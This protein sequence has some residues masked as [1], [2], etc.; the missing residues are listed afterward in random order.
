MIEWSRYS[1]YFISEN[2]RHFKMA[3]KGVNFFEQHFLFSNRLVQLILGVRP[4][5]NFKKQLFILCSVIIY[6]LPVIIHQVDLLLQSTIRV[7]QKTMA[8]LCF[9]CAYSSTYFSFVTLRLIYARIKLDYEKFTDDDE[10]NIMKK[11]KV[12]Q[13]F[14]KHS[15]YTR[16]T[17]YFKTPRMEWNWMVDIIRRYKNVTEYVDLLNDFSKITYLITVFLSVILIVTDFVYLFK[18]SESTI[19]IIECSLYIAVSIITIYLNFYF[20]QKLL[21]YSNAVFEELNKIPFYNLSKKFQ[22]LLLFILMRSRKPCVLSIGDMFVS[23][24]ESFAAFSTIRQF[25]MAPKDRRFYS[26]HFFFSNRLF[27]LLF[28][29]HPNQSSKDQLILFFIITVLVLPAIIHQVNMSFLNLYQLLTID[30]DMQFIVKMLQ[31]EIAAFIIL[32]SYSTVYYRFVTIK[33]I[34]NRIKLDYDNFSDEEELKIIKK[35]TKETKL[36]VYVVVGFFNLYIILVTSPTILNV[37]LYNF[38]I[39]DD[40]QLTL[41]LP[42]NDVTHA[43][44]LFYSLLIYQIIISFVLLS[45]GCLFYSLY[46]VIVQHACCQF[47]IIILKIHR[48]FNKNPKYMQNV[49]LFERPCEEF[50]WI[51]DIINSYNNVTEFIHLINYY[52]KI[53]YLIA[54]FFSMIFVIFDFIYIFQ[55]LET[56]QIARDTIEYII[57]VTGSIFILYLNFYVGQKL[58]DQSNAVL[59]ELCKIPYYMLSIKTQKL[60]LFLIT[61]CGKPSM[62]SIGGILMNC[63]NDE[64][65]YFS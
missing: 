44:L 4:D 55:L 5:Q 12:R 16:G 26:E 22:K 57:I 11:I 39:L 58:L 14:T 59:E 52:S 30:F 18:K 7:L 53:N 65:Y 36:Y 63:V 54:V 43:G 15:K 32:S 24:H 48:P 62:L 37:F 23:S 6:V 20:G 35:Y 40:D 50:D 61:R 2:V 28:G 51:V 9:L 13:P 3:R 1:K 46:L 10:I 21:N 19:E 41:P 27:Q 49:L 45:I 64:I 47:S 34:M 29:L 33:L 25:T 17:C 60:L 38:N 31:K 42:V 8:S 56:L